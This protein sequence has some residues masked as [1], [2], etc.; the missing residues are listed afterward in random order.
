MFV[1]KIA[2]ITILLAQTTAVSQVKSED[3]KNQQKPPNVAVQVRAVV[4]DRA[5]QFIQGLTKE[6]FLLTED[7]V[8]QSV[9][10]FSVERIEAKPALLSTKEAPQPIPE[11]AQGYPASPSSRVIVLLVDTAHV[12]SN[13]LERA[14]IALQ[15]FIDEQKSDQDL[16]AVMTSSG[17]PG[18][19][20]EFTGDRSKLKAEMKKVRPGYTQFESFLTPVLCGKVVRRDP[21]A[22]SLAGLIIDSEDRTSGSVQMP[23]GNTQAEAVSKCMMVLLESS[24]RR[25]AVVTSIGTAVERMSAMPGQ[26]I[27]ALFTEGFSMTATG[28]D[29]AINEVRPAISSAVRSG[30]LIY[31]FDV[32][33]P[34]SSKQVNIESYSLAGEILNSARDIQHGTSLLAGQTGG[35]AFYN[36]DGLSGQLQEM[37]DKNRLCYRLAYNPP[38]AAD[39]RKFRTIGVAIKGHPEYQVSAQKGYDMT[40]PRWAR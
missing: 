34:M 23:G 25:R 24:S 36:L 8:Q 16:I 30:V 20:G 26:H 7:G 29:I 18:V 19:T 22:V 13:G 38:Q 2:L 4:T 39:P 21:E 3:S 27:I 17:K 9:H 40:E 37:L 33:V 35:D 14:R 28:G 1:R 12:S 32:K 11:A 5:G 31:T 15:H 6:D 10:S